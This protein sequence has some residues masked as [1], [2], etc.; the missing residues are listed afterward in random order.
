M[1]GMYRVALDTWP[2]TGQ[3]ILIGLVCISIQLYVQASHDV[4]GPYLKARSDSGGSRW[5][6]SRA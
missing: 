1:A 6:D 2:N 5:P 3:G 4:M